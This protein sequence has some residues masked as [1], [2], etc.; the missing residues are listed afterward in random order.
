MLCLFIWKTQALELQQKY[1][2]KLQV[3]G[4][5]KVHSDTIAKNGRAQ[6][7]ITCSE[8]TQGSNGLNSGGEVS[9]E[10]SN[11]EESQSLLTDLEEISDVSDTE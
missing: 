7:A 10:F 6:P 3:G 8:E 11:D 4:Q 5:Q 2:E 9:D 1:I